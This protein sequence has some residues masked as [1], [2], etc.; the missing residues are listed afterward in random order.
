MFSTEQDRLPTAEDGPLTSSRKEKQRLSFL[1][2]PQARAILSRGHGTRPPGP[3][4]LAET[5]A[6]RKHRNRAVRLLGIGLLTVLAISTA[7]GLQTP[8]AGELDN[9]LWTAIVA[10]ESGGDPAASN[11]ASGALGVAQICET[12]VDDCNRIARRQKLDVQFTLADRRSPDR[13]RQMWDLYLT[14]YGR[15]YEQATGQPATNEVYARIWN[16]GPSGWRKES[17]TEYWTRVREIMDS[18][19]GEDW[20]DENP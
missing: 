18:C 15:Q 6:T 4:L 13:A 9:R 14:Y 16:G 3:L 2:S 17:T 19:A 11:P 7:R 20:P 10:V 12:C 8:P 5:L 1:L